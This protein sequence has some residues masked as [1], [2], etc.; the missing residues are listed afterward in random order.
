[1]SAINYILQLNTHKITNVCLFQ[2]MDLFDVAEGFSSLEEGLSQVTCPA[3]IIGVQTDI[4]FPIWQQRKL[5]QVLQDAGRME[6]QPHQHPCTGCTTVF[7]MA[8]ITTVVAVISTP[9][10]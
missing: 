6:R 1:M 3:M 9:G 5:A 10:A 4:L 8:H 7:H 2:A